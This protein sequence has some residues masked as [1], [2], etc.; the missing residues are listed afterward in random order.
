MDHLF[1][2]S[3]NDIIISNYYPYNYKILDF[4]SNPER[5]KEFILKNGKYLESYTEMK[6]ILETRL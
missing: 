6:N 4:E 5:E 3:P 1:E 2:V